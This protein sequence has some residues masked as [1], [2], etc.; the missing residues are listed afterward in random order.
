MIEG[1]DAATQDVLER[2]GFEPD[3][4]ESLRRRVAAGELS[5]ESNVVRGTVEP[6][7]MHRTSKGMHNARG[8]AA[9]L[10]S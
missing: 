6:F 10:P 5:P 7:V 8:P 3:T 4:F 9:Q 1:V 2:F